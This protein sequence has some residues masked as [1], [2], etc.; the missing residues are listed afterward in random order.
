[1]CAAQHPRIPGPHANSQR[2]D[3]RPCRSRQDHAGR[4]AP[5]PV[6]L[7]PRPPGGGRA[8]ARP[9]RPGA[10]ARHH[11]PGQV[12]LGGLARHPH[13]HRRYPRPRRFRRRGRAH[14]EHGGRRHRAGGR[15][16]GRAAA[17]QV[18]GRQGAGAWAAPDRGGQQGGSRR[19]PPGRGPHRDFRPV[20]RPGR[21]GCPA[22][23]PDAVRV[24]APRLGRY[25][26]GRPAPGPVRVVR[27]GGASRSRSDG[28]SR[29]AVR[30]GRDDHG[31]RSVPGPRTDR[32]GGT[33]PRADQHAG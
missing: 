32:P 2:R 31:V 19:R 24:R 17:D 33:G 29:R 13:Q 20:C 9:Q 27:P 30:H 1:M 3:H 16:R 26:T 15:R 14:P 21:L 23:L 10:R 8:R 18:R 22:R 6:R 11:D 25:D 7:V 28:R 4:Q 5:E 12:H